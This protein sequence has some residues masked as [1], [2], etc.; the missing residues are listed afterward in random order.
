MSAL[1]L[2]LQAGLW[3][4]LA[5]GALL[6]GAALGY[7]LDVPRRTVAA[8]MAFGSGV[9]HESPLAARP[10]SWAGRVFHQGGVPMSAAS[11]RAS[12]NSDCNPSRSAQR[13]R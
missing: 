2:W 5:G 9:R 1:P 13:S 4:G 6:V 3:C 12:A 10:R 7:W 11:S 8:V